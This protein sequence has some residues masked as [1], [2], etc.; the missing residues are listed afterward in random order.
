MIKKILHAHNYGHKNIGDDAMAENVYKK[1]SGMK[2]VQ[3]TTVS[4]Y[5]PPHH[6]FVS[7]IRSLSAIVNNYHSFICKIFLVTVHR[8][9]LGFF[10]LLYSW[11]VC[12]YSLLVAKVYKV[13]G[14][15]LLPAG[16]MK[17]LILNIST[18]N[19]YLRSGSGSLNDIWFWSSMYPQ[20]TEARICNT[21]E[22]KVYFTGQGLG[23]LHGI[24]RRKVLKDFLNC[25]DVITFRDCHGSEK[26]AQEVASY[27]TN[28]ESVGDDALDY[29]KEPLD[30]KTQ[31]LF[32]QGSKVL[33]CQFRPTNYNK[34][35]PNQYWQSVAES[36]EAFVESNPKHKV[37]LV[38]F[39]NG[40][41][42]DVSAAKK[43]NHYAH[44]K[45]IVLNQVY[46]PGQA[47]TLIANAYITIGQSYHF[48]VFSL[49]ES[50]PFI[51]LYTNQYYEN[52]H[53]GLLAWY[54]MERYA[55]GQEKVDKLRVYIEKIITEMEFLKN[56]MSEKNRVMMSRINAVYA[57]I[58]S[59]I[60]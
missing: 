57:S 13:T 26:L 39:S 1:L 10:Y 4:T 35:L 45:L 8:L 21:F 2:N 25:C 29:P 9:K 18:A 12:Q 38:S 30:E 36:L 53:T 28:Y 16:P 55:I 5:D 47:K 6:E 15:I 48:G 46:S 40:R 44:N 59:G 34:V 54:Q 33:V 23:P 20:Y 14:L 27:L 3:V 17:T 32:E 7:D 22:V 42:N 24:Y 31:A 11:L 50:V 49:A 43:I 19:I 51:A 41:V 52:K 37:V 60:L 58:E 56:D